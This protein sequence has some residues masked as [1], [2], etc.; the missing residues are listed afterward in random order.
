[1]AVVLPEELSVGLGTSP[2]GL[3]IAPPIQQVPT[4]AT[5]PALVP[6]RLCR[7]RA[8][9]Y[10]PELIEMP[11]THHDLIEG[12]V[13][14]NGVGVMPVCNPP[15]RCVVEIDQLGML[16]HGAVVCLARIMILDQ[17]IP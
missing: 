6:G 13:V 4:L 2:I 15:T 11:H 3:G 16:G 9:I 12:R 8:V 1:M 14:A 5:T 7:R 17:V 10:D